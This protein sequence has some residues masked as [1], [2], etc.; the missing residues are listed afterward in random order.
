M[1]SLAS[2]GER[3]KSKRL[4][5]ESA[6]KTMDKVFTETLTSKVFAAHPRAKVKFGAAWYRLNEFFSSTD[7]ATYSDIEEMTN[8]QALVDAYQAEQYIQDNE[9]MLP[10]SNIAPAPAIL[11]PSTASTPT[12]RPRT[13]KLHASNDNSSIS[14]SVMVESSYSPQHRRD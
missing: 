4:T 8:V 11:D 13:F 12:T 1:W 10:G 3:P 6:D 14:I 2:E 5:A 9:P 7:D